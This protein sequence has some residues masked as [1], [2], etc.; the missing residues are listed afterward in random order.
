MKFIIKQIIYACI[1]LNLF[2]LRK[3]P[4]ATWLSSYTQ[5]K[6]NNQFSKQ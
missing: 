6:K 3:R 1:R 5:E 2:L 4:I